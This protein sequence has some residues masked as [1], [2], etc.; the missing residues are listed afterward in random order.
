MSTVPPPTVPT[1]IDS[2]RHRHQ[3]GDMHGSMNDMQFK[4]L[5]FCA[6]SWPVARNT[7]VKIFAACTLNVE[8]LKVEPPT[9]PAI[10][11]HNIVLDVQ[12]IRCFGACL[13]HALDHLLEDHRL[14]SDTLSPPLDPTGCRGLL[15]LA[16][17]PR[18]RK[19]NHAQKL[20]LHR[21]ECLLR[22]LAES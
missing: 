18:E 1:L 3:Q 10:A 15:V 9:L 20:A 12:I 16:I 21:L 8:A 17:V 4:L 13:Q 6:G 19:H 22:A 2:I 5:T 11:S 14:R 7:A